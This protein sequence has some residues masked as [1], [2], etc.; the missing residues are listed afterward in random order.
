M[1]RG[2]VYTIVFMFLVSAVF[3]LFLA[4]TNVLMLR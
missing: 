3:T 2:Y 1:K 4:G